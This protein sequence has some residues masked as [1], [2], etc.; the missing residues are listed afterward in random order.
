VTGTAPDELFLG[1]SQLGYG[2]KFFIDGKWVPGLTPI[3]NPNPHLT[4]ERKTETNIGIDFGMFKGKLNG[5]IDL[6]S[7]RTDGLLY[8]YAVPSPPNLY[9]TT[10][11]NVG[12][13]DNKGIELLLS[14]NVIQK[15]KFSWTTSATFSHNTNKLVS[16]DNDLYKATNPWFNAGT[17]PS[18]MNTYSH[19]VEVGKPIGNF[20]GYK[21]IDITSDGYWVYE[22]KNGNPAST[23]NE[24][25]K[26]VIGNGLPKYYL[27]WNNNLRY[28]NFD[29]DISMRGAFGFQIINAQRMLFEVPGFTQYN[30]LVSAYDKVFGKA[31]LNKNVYPDWNSYYVENGDYWKIDNV[32]LGYNF[33]VSGIKHIKLARL[34]VATLNTLVITNYKGM[35][36]EVNQLGLN[37]GYD[38]RDKYPSTRTYT[39][40]LNITFN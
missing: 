40:G 8:D 26:K 30:Q 10:K 27:S 39:F 5:S 29:L 34:Y 38:D 28:G 23:V 22:D 12:V 32:T 4:W 19:R 17:T 1:V 15:Q 21:V 7:R 9:T 13:M 24:E 2:Q 14:S 6:Y 20:W 37:P 36:P 11:A 18:P 35:D 25:D 3:N 33:P 16:L 31:V